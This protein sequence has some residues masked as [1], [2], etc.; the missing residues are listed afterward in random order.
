MCVCMCESGYGRCLIETPTDGTGGR[1]RS[2]PCSLSQY[3]P[4]FL[5]RM[6]LTSALCHLELGSDKQF[7]FELFIL[8][9]DVTHSFL[10]SDLQSH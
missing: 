10:I 9:K 6:Q 5:H 2:D 3:C 7:D 4:S 8:R 1:C